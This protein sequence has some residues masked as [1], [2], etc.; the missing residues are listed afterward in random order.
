MY[1]YSNL[2]IGVAIS[3]RD[4]FSAKANRVTASM[5]AMHNNAQMVMRKNLGAL[6]SIGMGMSMA[7]VGG[8]M[9]MRGWIRTGADFGYSM[10]AVKAVTES[11]TAEFNALRMEALRL[12]RTTKFTAIEVAGGMEYMAKA[13]MKYRDVMNSISSATLL[14]V[15]TGTE[16]GGAGGTADMATNILTAFNLKSSQFDNVADMITAAV[17]KSNVDLT[18]FHEAIKYSAN[19]FYNANIDFARAAAVIGTL[20][21]AGIKGSMAGTA[22]GN[23]IRELTKA[24]TQFRTNR[25]GQGLAALG[26]APEDILDS[27]GNLLDILDIMDKF[28]GKVT[29]GDP[30]SIAAL[31][32][33]TG[34]R[35]N[36]AMTALVKELQMGPSFRELYQEI[37]ASKGMTSRVAA[38]MMDNL[39]GDMIIM[40]SAWDGFKIAF[41]DA[42]EPALR[43]TLQLLTKV[44]DKI[45]LFIE[46][47]VGKYL[48]VAAAGLVV[49]AGIAGVFLTVLGSV[50]LLIQGA[51]VSFNAMKM[52]GLWA[53]NALIARA[54]KYLL[55]LMGIKAAEGI[56]INKSGQFYSKT[57][58]RFTK[59]PKGNV[60]SK[61]LGGI[62]KSLV[63][64]AP[65]LGRLAAGFAGIAGVGAGTIAAVIAG[66]IGVGV[67]IWAT[68]DSLVRGFKMLGNAIKGIVATIF[69]SIA[70]IWDLLTT[71]SFETANQNFKDRQDLVWGRIR[72]SDN[73]I[74]AEGKNQVDWSKDRSSTSMMN[75]IGRGSPTIAKDS[76]SLYDQVHKIGNPTLQIEINQTGQMLQKH[77]I[78]M[79]DDEV[80]KIKI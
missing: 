58:G 77:A 10:S 33:V 6:R 57:T 80:L 36:R 31:G 66:V 78:P 22:A 74:A 20:G 32:A 69:H 49:V 21:N 34:V 64:I 30:T 28:R 26:L 65:W 50:G 16:L 39:K 56:G 18:D 45:T 5:N 17:N 42:V 70:Y 9:A 12:G 55:V 79:T 11:T 3:L 4:Q 67:A 15:A 48:A 63:G 53:Y 61:V 37:L 73:S 47:P 1:N 23:V 19:D 35:G 54:G 25:Q 43:S 72:Q 68:W 44:V 71:W 62:W 13:G 24:V 14:A 40:Q 2:G 51:A 8:I 59:A 38:E 7:S 27:K 29:I 75:F 46:T 76:Q 52:A 41:T 60:F